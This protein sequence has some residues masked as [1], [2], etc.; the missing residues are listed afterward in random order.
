V[1]GRTRA[2]EACLPGVV[3]YHRP[4][5]YG[6]LEHRADLAPLYRFGLS[7]VRVKIRA[8]ASAPTPPSKKTVR[9]KPVP[10]GV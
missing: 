1:T 8:A 6:G 5:T 9:Q 10:A 4:V 7:P 2:D 3:Y